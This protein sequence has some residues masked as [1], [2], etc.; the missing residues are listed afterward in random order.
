M[1]C[2]SVS[3]VFQIMLEE[4]DSSA[5][6]HDFLSPLLRSQ[7]IMLELQAVNFTLIRKSP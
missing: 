7:S 3:E 6:L 5:E 1:T 4:Y 2:F